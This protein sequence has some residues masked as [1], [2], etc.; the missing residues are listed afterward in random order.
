MRV[1]G[2]SHE[3][4]RGIDVAFVGRALA[5]I[6]EQQGEDEDGRVL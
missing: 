5:G 1:M 4:Q 3:A 2:S 6:V